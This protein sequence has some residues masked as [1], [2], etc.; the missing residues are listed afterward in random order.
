VTTQPAT[1]TAGEKQKPLCF[2]PSCWQKL[3]SYIGTKPRIA[4]LMSSIRQTLQ[5][6]GKFTLLVLA[7]GLVPMMGPEL[8]VFLVLAQMLYTWTWEQGLEHEEETTD[9]NSEAQLSK[10]KKDLEAKMNDMEAT[11]LTLAGAESDSSSWRDWGLAGVAGLASCGTWMWKSFVRNKRKKISLWSK[12]RCPIRLTPPAQT[13]Y[14][15]MTAGDDEEEE[16]EYCPGFDMLNRQGPC[17][18]CDNVSMQVADVSDGHD[19]LMQPMMNAEAQ[20]HQNAD[21]CD[22]SNIVCEHDCK[23]M[24]KPMMNTEAQCNLWHLHADNCDFSNNVCEE[25][26]KSPKKPMMKAEARGHSHS[27][28]DH[29][30]SANNVCEHAWEFLK[31]PMRKAEA[32]WHEHADNGDFSNNVREHACKSLMKLA[33][34]LPPD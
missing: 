25:A 4:G 34:Y 11:V 2:R 6:E 27:H 3:C 9:E 23:S 16:E 24:K 26:S 1:S 33:S 8:A 29:C 21:Y 30:E 32:K 14:F 18:P 13:A 5:D 19:C 12:V 22:F 17:K 7:A 20:W 15:D 28:V 10:L 31:K